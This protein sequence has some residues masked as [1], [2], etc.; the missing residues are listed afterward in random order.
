[1][2]SQKR[3]TRITMLASLAAIVAMFA[4][5]SSASAAGRGNT[6]LALDPGAAA[7]LGSLGVAVAPI[8]PATAGPN[9]I[10]FPITGLGLNWHPLALRV[11]H[12]GGLKF[13]AGSTVVDLTDYTIYTG[14]DARLVASLGTARVA[15]LKLDLSK[16]RY[17]IT[18]GGV[19]IGNVK[20][21][22]T[23]GAAGALN[24]AFGTTAFTEGLLIGTAT[25]NAKLL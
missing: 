11:N 9:G 19:T 3:M 13:S 4:F 14:R 21:S 5:S 15:I 17:G 2:R 25:V 6:T 22:L 7:A 12:S 8:A 20:A 16:A 18:W 1:M 24:G 10:A 23:A